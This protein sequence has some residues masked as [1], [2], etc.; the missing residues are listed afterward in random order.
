MKSKVLTINPINL[1]LANVRVLW[2]LST[3][4]RSVCISNRIFQLHCK[5]PNIR[6]RPNSKKDYSVHFSGKMMKNI[7]ASPQTSSVIQISAVA[8]VPSV[9]C[10]CQSTVH[11]TEEPISQICPVFLHNKN[12][13][14]WWVRSQFTSIIKYRVFNNLKGSAFVAQSV[15]V[16][17]ITAAKF[18]HVLSM[19]LPA[20][21]SEMTN[22]NTDG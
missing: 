21:A 3:I 11:S 2:Y 7:T 1:L 19:F 10:V 6:I 22:P 14:Q 9:R 15:N 20:A 4:Y 12:V 5:Q 16:S 13:S 17:S 8:A 18:N